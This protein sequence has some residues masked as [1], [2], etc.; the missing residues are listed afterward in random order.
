MSINLTYGNFAFSGIGNEPTVSF[1][2]E[3]TR[4]QAGYIIGVTD[5]IKL[6][7]VIFATGAIN[8]S[9]NASNN[10]ET[11]WNQLSAGIG[12]LR[13]GLQDYN[14]L[15]IK[16]GSSEIYKS[17][18]NTTTI[19]SINF[20][21]S[22]DD[23]WL[24]VIDY[25]ITLSVPNS[26]YINY[27]ADSG[28]YI[29]D[30]EDSYSIQIAE[31]N[32]YYD[33]P[34]TTANN[35]YPY[36]VQT[37]KLPIY[38]ITRNL[39]ANGIHTKNKNSIDNAKA[40][41]SGLINSNPKINAII[42]NLTLLDRSTTINTNSIDGTYSITD[43]FIAMSGQNSSGWMDTFTIN[44]E[45]D[46]NLLRTVS[47]QGTVKGYNN[48]TGI[49]NIYDNM[50]NTSFSGTK[51]INASG[52]F[53]NHIRPK[54]FTRVLQTVFPTGLLQNLPKQYNLNTTLNPLPVSINVDH[55]I[56]EGTIGYS[57]SYNSRPLCLVSGA[58]IESIN[59]E[60]SF[61]TRTYNMQDVYYRMPLPQDIGTRSLPT[62]TVTYE[63]TFP[64]PLS[65][66]LSSSVNQ[67]I[68]NL[69]EQ[70]NPNKLT[71]LSSEQ[72]YGPGYYSWIVANEESYDVI[73][74]KYT[75]K[76]GWQYQ[77]GFFPQGY[78]I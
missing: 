26:G 37:S 67:Q 11:A 24:K 48:V 59:M 12:V 46:N 57:Y 4:S 53:Y 31:D 58:I 22:T 42:N 28:Y 3:I 66:T 9:S 64:K 50:S 35:R 25:T 1:D 60:D 27:I 52:G 39:S 40:F 78:Y 73:A 23:N 14:S 18:P 8:D 6:N 72:P 33:A 34:A 68:T 16:C 20:N 54:I 71:P 44:S 32:H 30:F 69:I 21:N 43:N 74:G 61:S 10:K 49:P 17:D 55:N 13:T 36:S 45:V 77:K 29:S 7:G 76:I 41:I 56:I 51:F 2:T 65:G 19:D 5:K 47:I 15:I 63:A 75:K 70:F 62:R 38:N